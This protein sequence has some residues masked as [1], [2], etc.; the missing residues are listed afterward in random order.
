MLS[1]DL[2]YIEA[3]KRTYPTIKEH[4]YE[5]GV[6]TYK[7]MF[8]ANLEIK[9]LFENTPPEQS[10]RLIDTVILYCEE[11][12]NFELI[13][14]KLDKIAHVHIQHGVKNG[15]YPIMKNAFIKALCDTLDLEEANELVQAWSY[16]LDKLSH[17]LIHAENLIRKYSAVNSPIVT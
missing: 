8:A 15:Y 1:G 14:D 17:E 13:Y 3:L 6:R 10:Q 2:R 7:N 5:I 16:G 11:I 9:N 4:S 12:D